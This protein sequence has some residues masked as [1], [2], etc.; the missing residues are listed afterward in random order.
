MLLLI[1]FGFTL[2]FLLLHRKR[3]EGWELF[4]LFFVGGLIFH[5]FWEGKSQ[6]TYPYVFCLIPFAA[7]AFYAMSEKLEAR[8]RALFGKK[9][10]KPEGSFGDSVENLDGTGTSLSSNE[11]SESPV[12]GEVKEN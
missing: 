6:Y 9:K 8:G 12:M 2:I 3:F 5:T 1:I 11:I 7:Y 4:T 10:A